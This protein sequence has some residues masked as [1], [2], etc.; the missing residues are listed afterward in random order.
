MRIALFCT[1]VLLAACGGGGST[2][3]D[4]GTT[5]GE[6]AT[7]PIAEENETGGNSGGTST[8]TDCG[9]TVCD[10]GTHCEARQVQCI[11]A[12]CPPMPTCV[13]N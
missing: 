6:T 9:G 13:P 1:M 10:P 7:Q 2:A 11:R 5:G 12:P 4:D 8:P 3:H